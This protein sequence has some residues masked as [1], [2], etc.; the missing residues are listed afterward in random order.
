VHKS[1]PNEELQ[2]LGAGFGR[3]GTLSLKVALEE[4]GMGPCLHSLA[5]LPAPDSR[6]GARWERL[7]AGE[8]IDWRQALAGYRSSVDW[9]CARYYDQVLA[10]FPQA[11][12]ILSVREPAA[13]YESASESLHATRA[14][15]RQEHARGSS[16]ALLDAVDRA[17]WQELF[18]GRFPERDHALDVFARHIEAVIA[19]VPRQRLL[20]FDVREGWEPL[21]AFLGVSHPGTPF[22][23]LN[24]R[25]VFW[26]RL[27]RRDSA[28]GPASAGIVPPAG[29]RSGS[30]AEL[31]NVAG[32]PSPR[33]FAWRA[34]PDRRERSGGGAGA[35]AGSTRAGLS[36]AALGVRIGG[37]ACVDAPRALTQEQVLDLLALRGDPFAEGVFARCGVRTR[38]LDLDRAMLEQNLQG[39]SA[40]VEELL[41]ERSCAAVAELGIEPGEVSTL[42]TSSLISLGCPTLAHRLIERLE[43]DPGTDK[44]HLTGIGCA[45][46]VP[47]VRLGAQAL[48][49]D[50]RRKVLVV[51][52][53][54]MS[55]LLCG[56]SAA[57]A[58]A[59]TIG[60]AIFGDGTAALVLEAGSVRGGEEQVP[61]SH[62]APRVIASA[63]H[64]IPASLEAVAMV[65]DAQDSYLGLIRELPDIAGA[66]LRAL[67]D[68]F[69]ARHSLTS[70]M[71]D[72]WVVHPGG[73]RIIECAQ[74]A[75][76]LER[77]AVAISYEVL[78]DRG[79]VGTPSIFYVLERTIRRRF[80]RP[81]QH[82]L[83]VT[84]GPG[85]TV[86]LM[87]VRF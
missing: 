13:W 87:L 50:P 24:G 74:A 86:G 40:R 9:L 1:Q 45:S 76:G 62:P 68:S 57:D 44:Y 8:Q 36:G 2:V 21:C 25:A 80:P 19:H 54:S 26:T 61:A 52:A 77:D 6:A 60:S 42:I 70:H 20:V 82:G 4:L 69:L 38:R 28:Y 53:E 43:M 63:V 47:L 11:K 75:L 55:G 33:K 18:D 41:V 14:L 31:P 58:R 49:A 7:A 37:L 64:Q 39:R 66:N 3:T 22:P 67:V 84:V 46:A 72:H 27:G 81:G 34:E 48:A 30:C 5:A 73:R 59:K 65:S 15:Q 23:H 56:A 83:L 16:S 79:N 51:A 12:V 29:E 35:R 71:I 78:A 10:A 17:I 32:A 85:V